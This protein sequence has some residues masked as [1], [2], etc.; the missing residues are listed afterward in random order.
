MVRGERREEGDVARVVRKWIWE[1]ISF[2]N[3]ATSR[4]IASGRWYLGGSNWYG[5]TDEP[6][7]R[8]SEALTQLGDGL[9]AVI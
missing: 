7:D 3:N 9:L 1:R 2:R 6:A 4:T 8:F 5:S